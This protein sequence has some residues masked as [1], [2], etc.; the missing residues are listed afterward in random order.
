L[1]KGAGAAARK[2]HV[3]GGVRRNAVR[4]GHGRGAHSLCSTAS[5]RTFRSAC[6]PS[7]GQAR[8]AARGTH[9]RMTG[10]K[11][12]TGR[13]AASLHRLL[14]RR[15][16]GMTALI[17]ALMAGGAFLRMYTQYDDLD[18][19][20]SLRGADDFRTVVLPLAGRPGPLNRTR[21]RPPW[22][23]LPAASKAAHA[24]L[25]PPRCAS[26]TP[27]SGSCCPAPSPAIRWRGKGEGYLARHGLPLPARP[28][29]PE[30]RDDQHS[31]ANRICT[32]RVAHQQQGRG[33]RLRRERVRPCPSWCRTKSPTGCCSAC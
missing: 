26:L 1:A 19:E 16:L 6:A 29:C 3:H 32:C 27:R 13:L 15:L 9:E 22:I 21:C 24:R 12:R 23:P 20:N 4:R 18:I 28:G 11:A 33:A 31:A 8:R 25:Q 14:I 2:Y 17:C 5:S 7:A 30:P 10:Q